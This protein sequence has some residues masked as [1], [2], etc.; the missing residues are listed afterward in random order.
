MNIERVMG[1][2]ARSL[3]LTPS[4]SAV[5]LVLVSGKETSHILL[6]KR[7]ERMRAYAGDWCLPGG[8]QD[9]SDSHLEDTMWRELEEETGL[10][11]DHTCLLASLD[12]FYNGAG[13]LVRPFLVL[14]DQ[15]DFSS[16]LALQEGEV[17]DYECLPLSRLSAIKQGTPEG[18]VSRRSPGYFLEFAKGIGIQVVW[19]LTATILA[20]LHNVNFKTE[21]AIDHGDNFGTVRKGVSD[22]HQRK[23]V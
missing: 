3:P 9:A 12:D 11:R 22:G 16:D 4:P 2:R 1:Y 23:A 14:I 19:G 10:K 13:Q 15:D 7:P 18:L 8:R 17:A 20:H 6:L 21:L 5:A